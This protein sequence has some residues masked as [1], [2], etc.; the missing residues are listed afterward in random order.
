MKRN[1]LVASIFFLIYGIVGNNPYVIASVKNEINNQKI[2]LDTN[3]LDRLPANDYILGPGDDIKIIVSR[4]IPE[5]NAFETIDGEGTIYVPRLNRIYIEGLTLDELNLILNKAFKKFV[6]FPSVE[7]SITG[8]RPIRVLVRGE[9]ENP[10]LQTLQGSFS[11]KAPMEKPFNLNLGSNTMPGNMD[12]IPPEN[13]GYYFPT[14]FDVLRE[15]GGITQFSDISNI[16][17]IRKN[18]ISNGGGKIKTTLNFENVLKTGDNVQNIR[19]YDSDII[20]VKKTNNPDKVFLRKA[21]LSNLNPK[22]INVFVTGRIN[23]PGNTTVSKASVLTD[24][25]D[26]AGGAKVLR[27]PVTFLRFNNDGTIDKRKFPF[28]KNAKRGSFKNPYLRNG[29]LVVV[30]EST[31]STFNQILSE[32][33]APFVGIFSTYGLVKAIND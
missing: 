32:F 12:T 29:D 11:V 4:D 23:R 22:F 21:V 24:A 10:G 28:R 1:Y 8:Y 30:G 6:K 3:Y 26:I 19:I 5:L 7:V 25:I 15:S 17:V 31:I 14:V 33:T 2:E 18:N 20:I 13:E 9:V 27:G 16:E